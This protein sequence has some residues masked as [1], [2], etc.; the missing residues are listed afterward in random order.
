MIFFT[1]NLN[2]KKHFFPFPRGGG[3]G[4]RGLSK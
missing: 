1:E 3:G 4:A 2:K